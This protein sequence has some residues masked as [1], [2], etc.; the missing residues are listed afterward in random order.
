MERR[1]YGNGPTLRIVVPHN[2]DQL[3]PNEQM[4]IHLRIIREAMNFF[5]QHFPPV[6]VTLDYHYWY[7]NLYIINNPLY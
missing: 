1:H 2:Y 6:D 7:S 3:S 4:E 5:N